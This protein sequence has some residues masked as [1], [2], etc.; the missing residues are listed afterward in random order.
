M[1]LMMSA[2]A[3]LSA[4]PDG[5][6]IFQ[7]TGT[8]TGGGGTVSRASSAIAAPAWPGYRAHQAARCLVPPAPPAP[9]PASGRDAPPSTPAVGANR[10]CTATPQVY[11]GLT[12]KLSLKFP[13]SYPYEAPQVTFITPCFHPNVDQYGNICLDIL[14]VGREHPWT[15]A[16]VSLALSLLASSRFTSPHLVRVSSRS[17]APLLRRRSGPPCTTCAPSCSRFRACLAVRA[18]PSPPHARSSSLP[19][20][21]SA[22]AQALGALATRVSVKPLSCV[23]R[24][25][26]VLPTQ[27]PT[28]TAL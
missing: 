4:F 9:L 12:F 1:S 25:Y 14:K 22:R 26:P 8:I 5:D 3:S 18:S 6:N 19:T 2:D 21:L 27:T 24:L 16:T 20:A 13:T 11:E 7:W 10:S 15:A 23:R 17:Q 28:W